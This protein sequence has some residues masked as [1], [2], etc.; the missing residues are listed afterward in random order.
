MIKTEAKG[1]STILSRLSTLSERELLSYWIR[2]EYEE[3]ETYW[4]LAEKA[5]ELGLPERVVNTFVVLA[6]ESKEHGDRLREIYRRN[7][8]ELVDVDIP[9]VEA[10]VLELTMES[11]EDVV[12]VLTRAM[13][14]ELFAKNLYE[15]LAEETGSES[16]REVYLYLAEIEGSHYERLKC[17]LE[18]CEKIYVKG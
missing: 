5:K 12:D 13:K 8:G 18:V 4:K 10:E 17:E 6:K 3:A 1:F 15:K 2:G 14:A 11:P 9:G 16:L 7:Y